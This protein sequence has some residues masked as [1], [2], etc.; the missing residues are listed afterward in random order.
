MGRKKVTG[1]SEPVVD[2]P[3]PP[4]QRLALSILEFCD[5]HGISEGFYYKLKKQRQGPR[6]MKLGART[7][8][9]L[10]SAAEWRRARENTT[11]GS[12]DR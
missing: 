8:I 2:E 10:E 12:H 11:R 9:T 7:L 5:A 1:K 6:E 3:I 4:P